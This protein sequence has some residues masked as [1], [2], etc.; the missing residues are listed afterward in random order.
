MELYPSLPHPTPPTPMLNL[1]SKDLATLL[2]L[3]QVSPLGT[4]AV[5]ITLRGGGWEL[6]GSIPLFS[7][8][9]LK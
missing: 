8:K 4:T 5:K 6:T 2:P 3:L 9:L 1:G 7:V